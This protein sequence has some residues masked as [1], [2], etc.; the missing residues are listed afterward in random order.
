MR[1]RLLLISLIVAIALLPVWLR[2]FL[3]LFNYNGKNRNFT[4]KLD[5]LGCFVQIIEIE[6]DKIL[7][8]SIYKN[9]GEQICSDLFVKNNHGHVASFVLVKG[10]D[11]IFIVESSN[12]FEEYLTGKEGD[13]IN[14]DKGHE[15]VVS[16]TRSL[17]CR[18]RFI[19]NSDPRF[20]NLNDKYWF[21]YPPKDNN[22]HIIL[23][24][25]SADNIQNYYYLSDITGN[26]SLASIIVCEEVK[27]E[28]G[29]LLKERKP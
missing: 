22:T 13:F 18:C 17:H 10:I 21:G 12:Q 29:K 7:S 27:N 15:M 4:A 23:V 3:I 11:S 16:T 8:F 24:S 19:Q 5:N 25:H 6:H 26:D 14:I 1:K 20:F 2:M 28:K 9:N